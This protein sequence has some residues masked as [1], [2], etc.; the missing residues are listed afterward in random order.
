VIQVQ[1]LTKS[2]ETRKGPR[3]VLDDVNFDLAKGER[4]GVLGRNGSGKS[5][6]IRLISGAERAT[7]GRV[8]RNMSVSWPL[9]FAGAYQL[10]LTGMDN[11]RF[12][13]R[14]YGV[15][16]R[17]LVPF[18]EE[19]SELGLYLREPVQH[20][21]AGM[22]ARLSFAFS[23]AIEFDCF[24]IDEVIAVGDSRFHQKCHD[25]LFV[26]RGDRA[27]IIVSHDPNTIRH[28]CNRAAVVKDGRLHEF[29]SVDEAYAF[30]D[31]GSAVA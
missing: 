15:D 24:L 20:Y 13:C 2:Y 29:S 30:Y 31:Q 17:P 1:Q 14:V 8:V 7:S 11:F 28:Y 21:S 27:F 18:V 9:A 3:V 23:M 4:L 25:E 5:T 16:H 19:F 22:F 6:L 10:Q 26:K 12:L